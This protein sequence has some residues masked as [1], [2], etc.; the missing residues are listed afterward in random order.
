MGNYNQELIQ[1]CY[2]VWRKGYKREKALDYIANSLGYR[3]LEDV[4]IRHFKFM[5]DNAFEEV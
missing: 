3:P 2:E 5:F 1:A 4:Y